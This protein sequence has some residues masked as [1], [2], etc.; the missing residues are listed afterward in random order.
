MH[1][2]STF[3]LVI[4]RKENLGSERTLLTKIIKVFIECEKN[5]KNKNNFKII[6]LDFINKCILL[7]EKAKKGQVFQI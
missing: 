1:K 2:M 5:N 7:K 4:N 6:L 3:R